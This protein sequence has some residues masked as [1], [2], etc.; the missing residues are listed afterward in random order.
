MARK[1]TLYICR[2]G[3]KA[4]CKI[5]VAPSNNSEIGEVDIFTNSKSGYVFEEVSAQ[6]P[7]GEKLYKASNSINNTS[8][9]GNFLKNGEKPKI[10][11]KNNDGKMAW[12]EL[13]NVITQ[14]KIF[15]F[16]IFS[17]TAPLRIDEKEKQKTLRNN[18]IELQSLPLRID[19]FLLPMNIERTTFE[20]M[21]IYN[22]QSQ[23]DISMFDRSQRCP[24]IPLDRVKHEIFWHKFHVWWAFI[25]CVYA[26]DELTS[27][28]LHFHDTFVP[29]E[30]VLNRGCCSSLGAPH[31]FE[32][33]IL[34]LHEEELKLLRHG[35]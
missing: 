1:D 32:G 30:C 2:T 7:D 22:I 11:L 26:L 20:K 23:Y 15:L 14:K 12:F 35:A 21:S 25:R 9:H 13:D 28:R 8:W 33:R 10:H 34:D 27:Y 19:F 17:L 3:N 24:L 6:R 5:R 18:V 29:W 16:P 31:S 4:L